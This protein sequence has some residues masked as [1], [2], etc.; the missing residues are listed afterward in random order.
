MQRFVSGRA[1]RS[2]LKHYVSLSKSTCFFPGL[3]AYYKT[4]RLYVLEILN[5]KLLPTKRDMFCDDLLNSLRQVL[6]YNGRTK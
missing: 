2:L 6:S 4:T 1:P 5:L 3:T